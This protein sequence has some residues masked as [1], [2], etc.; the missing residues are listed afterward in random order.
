MTAAWMLAVVCGGCLDLGRSVD[1]SF[2]DS[3]D[4]SVASGD[5]QA[6]TVIVTIVD[7]AFEP[8]EITIPVG[9]TVLWDMQDTG[10]FHFVVEGGP[11]DT[12]HDFESPQLNAG[13]EWSYTF[14]EPG[15][16]L[17]YC[18]NHSTIM[19]NAKVTVVL[20]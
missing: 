10:T 4:S 14:T 8:N 9:T 15:E 2:F 12:D 17:Y 3:G 1:E 19:K 18:R 13:E 11:R 6:G 20:P 5:A 16:Y 7:L